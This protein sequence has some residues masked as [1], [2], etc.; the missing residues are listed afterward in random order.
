MLRTDVAIEQLVLLTD[1]FT[2]QFEFRKILFVTSGTFVVKK[3]EE[4]LLHLCVREAN[5]VLFVVQ[6]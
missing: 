2:E 6:T 4:C 1:V 3:I 5:T